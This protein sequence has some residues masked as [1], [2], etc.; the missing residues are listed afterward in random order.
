MH[1]E[2]LAQGLA[3]VLLILISSINS[4]HQMGGSESVQGSV[5]E[6]AQAGAAGA[7]WCGEGALGTCGALR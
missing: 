4:S 1:A 2:C 5:S 3:S 6:E 7:S